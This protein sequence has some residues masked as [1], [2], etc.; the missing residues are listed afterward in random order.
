ME[1]SARVLWPLFPLLLLIV[2]ICLT[3]ALVRVVRRSSGK[4]AVWLQAGA[5]VCYLLA[6]V[7]AIASEQGALSVNIHRPFSVLTQLAI[8]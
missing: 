4:T 3:W 6:A 2:V 1:L 8:A 5:L 7:S